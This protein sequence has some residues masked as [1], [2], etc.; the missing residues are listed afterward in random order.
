MKFRIANEREQWKYKPAIERVHKDGTHDTVNAGEDDY[1]YALTI[2]NKAREQDVPLVDGNG[3]PVLLTPE[4]GE[5]PADVNGHDHTADDD[6]IKPPDLWVAVVLD[7]ASEEIQLIIRP[8]EAEA[9][10]LAGFINLAPN[11]RAHVIHYVAV[12]F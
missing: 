3:H 11:R 9:L 5:V 7:D 1:E 2:I 4:V 10:I 8:D 12:P 6:E